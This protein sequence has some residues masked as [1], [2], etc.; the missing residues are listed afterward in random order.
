M[1]AAASPMK[2]TAVVPKA[3]ARQ[4]CVLGSAEPGSQ[5]R[6]LA[7]AAGELPGTAPFIS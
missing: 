7:A 3:R 5:A 2:Q 4:V 6:E 1:S